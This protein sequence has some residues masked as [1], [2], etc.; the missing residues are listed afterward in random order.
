MELSDL[1]PALLHLRPVTEVQRS[2]LRLKSTQDSSVFELSLKL[3]GQKDAKDVFGIQGPE[4][5]VCQHYLVNLFLTN[6][7][8][9]S[10]CSS[11]FL[12]I[13]VFLALS[14]KMC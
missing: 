7:V 9:I 3:S 2:P 11:L 5:H 6:L 13:A 1:R 8:R 10:R 14:G 12:A 4:K